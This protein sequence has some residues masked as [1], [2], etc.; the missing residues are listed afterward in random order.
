VRFDRKVEAD[1]EARGA[2]DAGRIV[3]ETAV[4][5][6]ADEARFDVLHAMRRIVHRTVQKIERDGVDR[7]IAAHQIVFEPSRRDRGQCAGFAVTLLARGREVDLRK[8]HGGH[9]VGQELGKRAHAPVETL[10][11]RASERGRVLFEREVD[12]DR[13]AF[14]KDVA[15]RTADEVGMAVLLQRDFANELDRAPLRVGEL[16]EKVHGISDS[17]NCTRT[18]IRCRARNFEIVCRDAA[19][20]ACATSGLNRADSIA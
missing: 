15:D 5:K 10:R 13:R 19:T 9:F 3:G 20:L 12:I 14:E 6:H 11:Q 16:L 8:V 18:R 7:E 4:V 1:G 2:E 17:Y